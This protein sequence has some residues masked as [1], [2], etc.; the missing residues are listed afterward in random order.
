MRTLT[1]TAASLFALTLAACGGEETENAEIAGAEREAAVEAVPGEAEREAPAQSDTD[2]TRAAAAE[3]GPDAQAILA[4]F[5]APYTGADLSNGERLWRRCQSCHTL[6]E[7]AR[8][9]VGPNLHGL[10]EREVGGA[11]GFRYS[12]A[13]Q[14]ADFE[15][16]PE[17]L[18]QWLADPRGFL[19]GNRMSFSG[20]RNEEDRTDL[21]AWLAVETAQ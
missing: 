19:P 10:F 8:H 9:M 11:E 6:P 7:G 2:D 4:G 5:G 21:I 3:N 13:L 18:D 15:W 20:L 16:S 14:Q 17:Q 12:S 1:L